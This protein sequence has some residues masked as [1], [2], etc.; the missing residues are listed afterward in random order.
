MYYYFHFLALSTTFMRALILWQCDKIKFHGVTPA[1]Q[2]RD[3][4]CT[5]RLRSPSAMLWTISGTES[6]CLVYRQ[7]HQR[8]CC[9]DHSKIPNH[10]CTR[11]QKPRKPTAQICNCDTSRHICG[12]SSVEAGTAAEIAA[13]RKKTKSMELTQKYLFVPLAC[14]VTGVWCSKACDFLSKLGSRICEVTGD[15]RE[16]SY[17]FQRLSIALQKGNAACVNNFPPTPSQCGCRDH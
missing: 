6:P 1:C 5:C 8:S 15:K 10:Q 9:P 13:V 3:L 17:L 7:S 12:I 4:A 16:T 11:R 2:S 14:E